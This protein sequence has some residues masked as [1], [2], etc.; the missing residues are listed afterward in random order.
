ML[1][2]FPKKSE[3]LLEKFQIL[4]YIRIERLEETLTMSQFT[5]QLSFYHSTLLCYIALALKVHSVSRF[6]FFPP[7]RANMERDNLLRGVLRLEVISD[8][9]L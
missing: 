4:F 7:I 9:L 6:P 3:K 1:S 2:K 8:A 5:S